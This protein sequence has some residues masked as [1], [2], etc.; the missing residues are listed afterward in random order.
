MV[1]GIIPTLPNYRTRNDLN[2]GLSQSC[3]GELSA[4]VVGEFHFLNVDDILFPLLRRNAFTIFCLGSQLSSQ[5]PY[6]R[7][8]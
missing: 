5:P 1:L 7:Y 6:S 4:Y 3:G 2:V 8:S